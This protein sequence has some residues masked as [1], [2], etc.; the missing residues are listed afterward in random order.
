M[1]LFVTVIA[2]N[3]SKSFAVI[4]FPI[5]KSKLINFKSTFIQFQILRLTLLEME[6]LFDSKYGNA[7]MSSGNATHLGSGTLFYY[8]TI[9]KFVV[10]ALFR[11]G[12]GNTIMNHTMFLCD[13]E[14]V[15][16]MKVLLGTLVGSKK[17]AVENLGDPP[18]LECPLQKVFSLFKI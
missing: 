3:L 6:F 7:S 18:K 17:S 1:K 13:D 8:Q 5:F 9:P 12:S 16:R 10:Q 2:L 11:T 4:L 14:S 15:N